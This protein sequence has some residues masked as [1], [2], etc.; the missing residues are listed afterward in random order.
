M[1]HRLT[2]SLLFA[3]AVLV[4]AGVAQA[5]N[6]YW[7][8]IGYNALVD[9]LGGATP[10]GA[11]V[12][13][14]I[15]E[16]SLDVGNTQYLPDA[17]TY[18]GNLVDRTGTGVTSSHASGTAR[19][20]FGT[21][22]IAPN[23]SD[24]DAYEADNFVG[25]G[26][27]NATSQNGPIA[28][29]GRLQNHSW[30]ADGV[31]SPLA[32]DITRRLDFVVD[33]GIAID[34]TNMEIVNG[35]TSIVALSN[36]AT[37]FPDL[38]GNSYNSIVVGLSDSTSPTVG[39]SLE[40]VGRSKPD[41]VSPGAW[42][43]FASTPTPSRATARVSATAT[44]LT[45]TA[46]DTA[47]DDALRPET[48]KALLM[49]GATKDEAPGWAHTDT[50]PL[51]LRWGAGEV[52]IDHSH[53]ILEAGQSEASISTAVPSVGWDL[54]TINGGDSSFY[55][56]EVDS[57]F[58]SDGLSAILTWHRRIEVTPGVGINSATLDPELADLNL[59]LHAADAALQLGAELEKSISTIDNVEHIYLP[60]LA[61][62]WYALEV[63]AIEDAVLPANETWQFALAWDALRAPLPGD[64]NNDGMV[65]G[66]DAN[67]ISLNWLLMGAT[68][69]DGD[70]NG[71][72]KVDGLD[73]NIVSSHWTAGAPANSIPEPGSLSLVLAAAITGFF[74]TSR[75]RRI[76]QCRAA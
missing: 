54:D 40:G 71:D 60:S 6:A 27:L 43:P 56:F 50:Q 70:L 23:V 7:E 49:A 9:R 62:G 29:F 13:V 45:Q 52:N 37:N 69:A 32:I 65:D 14:T 24:I 53:R 66:L 73:A 58:P 3:A 57:M 30:I 61:T 19:N 39:T 1:K 25:S 20:Y 21:E 63:E 10:T 34:S 68:R 12:N 59:R 74:M 4:P 55:F 8:D 41:L 22:S 15:V 26:F 51:D 17:G 31:S 16:A 76:R 11:G 64:I 36:S 72:G 47:Q 2:R 18:T 48:I 38:L 42:P 33:E 35:I 46:L 28:G 75:R 44:L 5:Q 67:I